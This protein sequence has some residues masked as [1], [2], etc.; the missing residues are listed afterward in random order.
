M[1]CK[2]QR[3]S[4]RLTLDLLLVVN[5]VRILLFLHFLLVDTSSCTLETQYEHFQSILVLFKF[6]WHNNVQLNFI[7]SLR[8]GSSD[9]RVTAHSSLLLCNSWHNLHRIRNVDVSSLS[10]IFPWNK[11]LYGYSKRNRLIPLHPLHFLLEWIVK[12]KK[13][14]CWK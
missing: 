6:H 10:Q 11:V 12:A 8:L 5:R 3:V 7:T 4:Y 9:S 2:L 13:V 1:G 14:T